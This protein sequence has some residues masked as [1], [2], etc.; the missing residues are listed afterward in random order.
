MCN[1][2]Y[3]S[4]AGICA[5][6]APATKGRVAFRKYLLAVAECGAGTTGKVALFIKSR[7]FEDGTL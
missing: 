1:V 4:K 2:R 3:A 5:A 7:G 6:N